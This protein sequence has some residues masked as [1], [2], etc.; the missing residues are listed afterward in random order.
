ME[1]DPIA[2]ERWSG[3]QCGEDFCVID[4]ERSSRRWLVL[5]ARSRNRIEERALA[6]A[7]DRAEISLLLTDIY[8]A[9]AS[10]VG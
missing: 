3:A 9:A 7:C 1:G 6:A 10:L 8:R 5:M 2:L 4:I